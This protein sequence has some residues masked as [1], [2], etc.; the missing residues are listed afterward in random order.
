M[1]HKCPHSVLSPNE[2]VCFLLVVLVR[3]CV[4]RACSVSFTRTAAEATCGKPPGPWPT[5]LPLP[6]PPLL[7]R[8][9][10]SA[11]ASS[12][13]GRFSLR[14]RRQWSHRHG[15]LSLP[16][17]SADSLLRRPTSAPRP[18][19]VPAITTAA[20]TATTAVAYPCI[21]CNAFPA[22]LPVDVGLETPSPSNA[23]L[24]TQ[25]QQRQQ[26][27]RPPARR[28]SCHDHHHHHHRHQPGAVVPP[29]L[30]FQPLR[31]TPVC[32]SMACS[33]TTALTAALAVAM[34]EALTRR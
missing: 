21:P 19:C 29:S 6:P 34:A 28:C 22:T 11:A 25:Q 14:Q 24:A 16:P 23:N 26:Q 18:V 31:P 13:L 9:S 17:L 7:L 5:M 30:P 4:C 8:P 15:R 1:P 3:A 10:S 33:A 12:R 27:Q 20:T 32:T 2:R